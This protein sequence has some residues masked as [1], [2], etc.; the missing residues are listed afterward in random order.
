MERFPSSKQPGW[1][2]PTYQ[3]YQNALSRLAGSS[4]TFGCHT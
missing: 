3:F 4:A 2:P 1:R